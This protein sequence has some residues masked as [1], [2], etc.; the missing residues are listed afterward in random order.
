MNKLVAE[1]VGVEGER[2]CCEPS[3]SFLVDKG[4]K[5]VDRGDG[6]VDSEVK[7]VPVQKQ[8]VSKILL[9]HNRL[10]ILD[11]GDL[12]N[13]RDS[14]SSRERDRLHNPNV[15]GAILLLEILISFHKV[16]ILFR[17]DECLRKNVE[18]R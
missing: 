17:Q 14:S 16:Y 5:G 13:Q 6:H 15:V 1:I 11:G 7:F 18:H 2:T 3:K 9:E 8:G 10:A 4:F 12:V